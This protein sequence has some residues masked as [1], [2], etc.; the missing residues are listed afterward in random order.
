MQGRLSLLGEFPCRLVRFCVHHLGDR[1]PTLQTT[2]TER[3]SV[4]Q[5]RDE[6]E[7]VR[8][9][10]GSPRFGSGSGLDGGRR[11]STAVLGS[12]QLREA[13]TMQGMGWDAGVGE[14]GLQ[15]EG[16]SLLWESAG[17]GMRK[18]LCHLN[19]RLQYV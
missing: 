15:M 13:C 5:R 16:W 11:G 17:G 1:I 18:R 12:G 4:Q 2:A 14:P 10:E 19:R 8:G 3:R 7:E 9:K 6:V